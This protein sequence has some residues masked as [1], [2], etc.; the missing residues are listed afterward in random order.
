MAEIIEKFKFETCQN[1]TL[2]LL[3]IIII[4]FNEIQLL[5]R[6]KKR[7]WFTTDKKYLLINYANQSINHILN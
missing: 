4:I 5:E 7:K 3:I 6:K 2:S 1:K